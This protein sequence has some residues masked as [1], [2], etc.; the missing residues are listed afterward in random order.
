MLLALG[1]LLEL[2]LLGSLALGGTADLDTGSEHLLELELVPC[3]LLLLGLCEV[4]ALLLELLDPLLLLLLLA[5]T[6]F[7]LALDLFCGHALLFFCLP[8]CLFLQAP[9]L[10]LSPSELL[11][12]LLEQLEGLGDLL[13]SLCRL[14]CGGGCSG[15]LILLLGRF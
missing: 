8:C 11:L 2:G 4:L 12:L 1:L 3:L 5:G 9:G 6:L 10:F 14:W 15:G 13:A 7:L